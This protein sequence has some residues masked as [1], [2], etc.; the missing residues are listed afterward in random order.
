MTVIDW[1]VLALLVMTIMYFFHNIRSAWVIFVLNALARI[2][3]NKDG[4]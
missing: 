3:P 1:E 2:F 4:E